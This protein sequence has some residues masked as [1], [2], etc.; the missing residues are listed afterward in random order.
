MGLIET[1]QM[2]KRVGGIKQALTNEIVLALDCSFGHGWDDQDST[3]RP[4]PTST[5]APTPAPGTADLRS[6]TR[7]D[8]DD[9]EEEA[10]PY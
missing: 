10:W 4:G 1:L 9:Q 7:W 5:A 6:G 3:T 8:H 2:I